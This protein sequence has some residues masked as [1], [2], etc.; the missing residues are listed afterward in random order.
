MSIPLRDTSIGMLTNMI[1]KVKTSI[2]SLRDG[3][4]SAVSQSTKSQSTP[5]RPAQSLSQTKPSANLAQDF[6][7]DT[8]DQEKQMIQQ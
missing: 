8:I 1:S 3:L 6:S 7:L 4:G 2:T 5:T